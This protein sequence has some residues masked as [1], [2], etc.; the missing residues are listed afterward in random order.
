MLEALHNVE[1]VLTDSRSTSR[2]KPAFRDP[3]PMLGE[4]KVD[5]GLFLRPPPDSEI[6]N[7]LHGP[8]TRVDG[9]GLDVSHVALSIDEPTPL[10]VSIETKSL[11]ADA[12]SGLSQLGNWV[13]SHFRALASVAAHGKVEPSLI[14]GALPILPLI[15][16]H[17]DKWR[18]DF[19]RR[20]NGKTVSLPSPRPTCGKAYAVLQYVHES[21]EL[22]S[23]RTVRGCYHI[24]QAL[25]ELAA[26]IEKDFTS[27]WTE[28]LPKVSMATIDI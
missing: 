1:P 10:A 4:N 9:L 23:T 7:W 11:R 8:L 22:G 18:L 15:F 24:R 12:I 2:V 28:L 20:Y 13:R 26:W 25:R 19:A 21:V 3:N 17:G 14:D 27:W 6:H 16:V 5:Y